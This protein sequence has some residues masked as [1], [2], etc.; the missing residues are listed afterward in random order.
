MKMKRK[1]RVESAPASLK[2]R[3]AKLEL[4]GSSTP[5]TAPNQCKHKGEQKTTFKVNNSNAC[6]DY[7]P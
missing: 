6:N 1:R 2:V 5:I 3:N 7:T 4:V